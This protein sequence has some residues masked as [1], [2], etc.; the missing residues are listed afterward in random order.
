MVSTSVLVSA[1]LSAALCILLPLIALIAWRR[2]THARLGPALWGALTF[3]LFTQGF[4]GVLHYLCLVSDN[5]VSRAILASDILYMLYGAF[6]AGIFEECG[7]FV[8]FQTALRRRTERTTAVTAGLGHGGIE[9]IV[10]GTVSTLLYFLTA[11][12]VIS[13]NEDAAIALA[14][15][16]EGLQT[17]LSQLDRFTLSYGL[18]AVLERACAM[19]LHVALSIIVFIAARSREKR[20]YLPLAVLLHAVF[21]MPVA[22]YQRGVIENL[23]ALELY[24]AV[25]ALLVLRGARKRYLEYC[26]A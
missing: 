9:A 1:G 15:S 5:A 25:T 18:L 24:L 4:E 23:W 6:A 14:G 2:G 17:V 19:T 3:L 11:Y 16:E 8:M 7:R 22:L 12:F 13:G 26:D 10:V 20:W 21:D